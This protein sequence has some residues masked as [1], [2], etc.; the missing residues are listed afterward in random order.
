MCG[1]AHGFNDFAALAS[2]EPDRGDSQGIPRAR[3]AVSDAHDFDE[4]AFREILEGADSSQDLL[5]LSKAFDLIGDLANNDFVSREPRHWRAILR[6]HAGYANH[7]DDV[8][9][10]GVVLLLR[11]L[12][13]EA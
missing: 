11:G 6:L 5:G 4:L 2:G 8:E 12:A 9:S 7:G 13:V 1:F 3:S 10:H